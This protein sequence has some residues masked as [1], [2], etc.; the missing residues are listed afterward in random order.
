MLILTRKR[1][2]QIVIDGNIIITILEI[3]GNKVRVGIEA[4][5][6]ISVNRK[7]I[8]DKIMERENS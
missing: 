2:E 5:S 8:H 4:P 3:Q 7:E 1:D 6:D